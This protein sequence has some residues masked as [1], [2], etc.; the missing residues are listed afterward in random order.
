M[1]LLRTIIAI[2]AVAGIAVVLTRPRVSRVAESDLESL[3]RDEL[4][5]MAQE[6]NVAGRSRMSKESLIAALRDLE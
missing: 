3:T 2:L 4:Y 1:R 6:R 5:R